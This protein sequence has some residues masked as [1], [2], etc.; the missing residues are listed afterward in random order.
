[1]YKSQA[2]ILTKY[3]SRT[4]I[5]SHTVYIT[6]TDP[7]DNSTTAVY[8]FDKSNNPPVAPTILSPLNNERVNSDFYVEFNIGSCL[9]YT[10][11]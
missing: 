3:W 8:T 11:K 10:S 5:G 9:L 4:T 1:M 2:S 7:Y 6:A